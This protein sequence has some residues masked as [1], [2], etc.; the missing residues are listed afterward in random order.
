ML[1]HTQ[2]ALVS[3]MGVA[4]C[5]LVAGLLDRENVTEK[6]K[7][8]SQSCSYCML[9]EAMELHLSAAVE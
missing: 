8:L 2:A 1:H 9:T 5:L 4:I 3:A 6:G 7:T